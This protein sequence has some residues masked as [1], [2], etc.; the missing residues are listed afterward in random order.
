MML[1]GNS[2]PTAAYYRGGEWTTV[3]G[4]ASAV[5][6]NESSE[7][8]EYRKKSLEQFEK[9]EG[10]QRKFECPPKIE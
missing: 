1:M 9:Y 3:F 7:S 8:S 10:L 5:A 4:D 6:G 2:G